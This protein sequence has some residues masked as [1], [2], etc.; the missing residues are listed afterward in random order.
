MMG[1]GTIYLVLSLGAIAVLIPFFWQISTSLKSDLQINAVPSQWIP[2]P[3]HWSNYP[4]AFSYL[5][6]SH[7]LPQHGAR[8]DRR[9]H[10]HAALVDHGGLCLRAA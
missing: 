7:L 6:F 8:R 9:A 4:D 1:K 2:R 10:R 3:A 5:P